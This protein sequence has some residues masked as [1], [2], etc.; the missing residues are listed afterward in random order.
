MLLCEGHFRCAKDISAV[1]KMLQLRRGC[2][3]M[4]KLFVWCKGCAKTI[5]RSV[6]SSFCCVKT[7]SV[8]QRLLWAEATPTAQRPLPLYRGHPHC[9]ELLLSRGLSRSPEATLA[10]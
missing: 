7:A 6:E 10:A 1:Q 3:V 9:A 4:Q 2:F 5:T 8:T